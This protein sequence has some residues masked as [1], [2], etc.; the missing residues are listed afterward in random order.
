MFRFKA[1]T[2]E[3]QHVQNRADTADRVHDQDLAVKFGWL[4][5]LN[6]AAAIA[7][8]VY[9]AKLPQLDGCM[10]LTQLFAYSSLTS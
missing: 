10:F 8:W 7:D 3:Q 2:A 6:T 5:S 1:V 9:G 4:S